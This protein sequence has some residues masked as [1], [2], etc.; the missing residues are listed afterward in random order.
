MWLIDR[1]FLGGVKAAVEAEDVTFAT[2]NLMSDNPGMRWDIDET[3]QVIGYQPKDGSLAQITFTIRVRSTLKKLLTFTI[4]RA[5][6][7]NFPSW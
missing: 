5:I 4:P 1:D 6:D 3:R 7:R 2:L